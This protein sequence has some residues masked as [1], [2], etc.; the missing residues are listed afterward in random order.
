MFHR[1]ETN[2]NI[3]S[4]PVERAVRK[5]GGGHHYF[6]SQLLKAAE[7]GTRVSACHICPFNRFT[8]FGIT[9]HLQVL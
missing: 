3:Q 8:F 6:G 5:V 2:V 4:T 9:F 1:S 7:L